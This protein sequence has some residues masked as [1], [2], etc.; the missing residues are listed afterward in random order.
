MNS[1]R[2]YTGLIICLCLLGYGQSALSAVKSSPP[3]IEDLW[4]QYQT[5]DANKIPTTRYPYERCFKSAAQQNDLPLSLLLAVARGE[6]NFNPNAKS[7]RN[8][9]GLTQIGGLAAQVLELFEPSH[10]NGDG[11]FQ[12][13]LPNWFD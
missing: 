11:R 2:K 12:V 7:N 5:G 1:V 10:D 3:N 6:S 4:K 9:H 13:L 8:C